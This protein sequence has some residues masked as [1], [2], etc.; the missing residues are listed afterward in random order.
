LLQRGDIFFTADDV[1]DAPGEPRC[2]C[3]I[4]PVCLLILAF[5]SHFIFDLLLLYIDFGHVQIEI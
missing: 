4:L 2:G 1:K 3:V 5:A